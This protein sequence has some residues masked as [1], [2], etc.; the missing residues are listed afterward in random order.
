MTLSMPLR[1]AALAVLAA[2]L[3][4]G[5][6]STITGVPVPGEVD[7][8]PLDIGAYPTDPLDYR[9]TYLHNAY[10]GTELAIARL[11]GFVAGGWE[12][13]PSLKRQVSADPISGARSDGTRDVRRLGNL[14][15]E[16]A[17]PILE[18][19]G[20]MFGFAMAAATEPAGTGVHLT[21]IQFPDI[22]SARSAATGIEAADLALATENAPVAL[23]RYPDVKA[24]WRPGTPALTA[25][26]AH[27][28]YLVSVFAERHDP[29]LTALRALT[30][31]ALAVQLP[32][33]DQ[34]PPLSAREIRRLDYDPQAM[35]RRTLHPEST[36]LPD[37]DKEA[38]FTPRG[39]VNATTENWMPLIETGGIDAIARVS[40]GA[41]QFRARDTDAATEVMTDPRYRDGQPADAPAGVPDAR[42]TEN[43]SNTIAAERFTCMVRH[44]RYIA[45]VASAQLQDAKQRAAAQYGLLVNSAWM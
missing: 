2:A 5:C 16:A 18:N 36:M 43:S 44:G 10:Y 19:H 45:R 8:R 42:C 11:A 24:H 28:N 12:I 4:T 15:T 6:G 7:I 26:L 3:L 21:V 31:Q 1:R 35:L 29:D 37:F 39:F 33:L 9:N 40:D 23:D 34:L 41:L 27:G 14:P 38:V 32:L 25:T 30:Q 20:M 22:E 17:N 13:D